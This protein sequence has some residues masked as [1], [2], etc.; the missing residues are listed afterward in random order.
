MPQ[1]AEG[2]WLC[3]QMP[4]PA[5]LN[6][7][8][9]CSDNEGVAITQPSTESSDQDLPYD[10]NQGSQVPFQLWGRLQDLAV[11]VG[12]LDTNDSHD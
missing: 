8:G 2:G 11:G 1:N 12:D 6:Q 5:S 7:L 9:I 10:K 3:F 4:V